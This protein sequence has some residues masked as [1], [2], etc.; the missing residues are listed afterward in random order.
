MS[1]KE[2]RTQCLGRAAGRSSVTRCCMHACIPDLPNLLWRR[3]GVNGGGSPL[4]L[5]AALQK[6]LTSWLVDIN[7]SK[8]QQ[9]GLAGS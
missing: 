3:Y 5:G 4:P 1:L 6:R 2:L 7:S 8:A 9:R